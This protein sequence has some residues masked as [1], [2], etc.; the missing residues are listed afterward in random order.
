MNKADWTT[1]RKREN[2][3]NMSNKYQIVK[4][5]RIYSKERCT[6]LPFFLWYDLINTFYNYNFTYSTTHK[7]LNAQYLGMI[8]D[9]FHGLFSK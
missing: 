2:I 9:F 3:A 1:V 6:L 8:N 4:K 5:V 7:H